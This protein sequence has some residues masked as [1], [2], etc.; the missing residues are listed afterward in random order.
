MMVP[1]ALSVMDLVLHSRT[2]RST[3]LANVDGT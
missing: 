2:G 3:F 1:I